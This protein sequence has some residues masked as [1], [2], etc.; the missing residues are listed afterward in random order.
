MIGI[1]DLGYFAADTGSSHGAA[2]V[3]SVLTF[4]AYGTQAVIGMAD[5]L[6]GLDSEEHQRLKVRRENINDMRTQH[7][8]LGL[9]QSYETAESAVVKLKTLGGKIGFF[10]REL[11]KRWMA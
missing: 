3:N 8:R 7:D 11:Y 2:A 4:S 5:E 1:I 9:R 6:I 10:I